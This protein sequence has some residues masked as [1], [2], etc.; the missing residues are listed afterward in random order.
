MGERS[1]MTPWRRSRG[2]DDLSASTV[3]RRNERYLVSTRL[4]AT[5]RADQFET[6]IQT[7]ALDICE[8]GIGTL[9]GEGWGVGTHVDLDV[10][11]PENARLEIGGIVRHLTGRRCGIEFAEVSAEQGQVLRTVCEFLAGRSGNSLY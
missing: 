3:K 10:S 8:S 2:R 5:V 6:K 9:A 7:R 4:T 1:K 11:L